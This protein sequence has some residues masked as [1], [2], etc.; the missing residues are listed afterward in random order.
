[1]IPHFKSQTNGSF[2][3]QITIGL[4]SALIFAL[5]IS[6][7]LTVI[8]IRRKIKLKR[9][10]IAEN[11]KADNDLNFGSRIERSDDTSNEFD[12]NNYESV[13]FELDK[14]ETRNYERIDYEELNYL[15]VEEVEYTQILN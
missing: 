2:S 6:T 8:I 7:F 11:S 10:Q 4:F 5:I 3:F 12:E 14:Y 13:D 9:K 1:M 15:R